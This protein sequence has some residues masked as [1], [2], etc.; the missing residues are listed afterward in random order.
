MTFTAYREHGANFTPAALIY[1]W[2]QANQLESWNTMDGIRVRAGGSV[3]KYQ[4]FAIA[5]DGI[6]DCITVYMEPAAA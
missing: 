2:A 6:R 4:Q 3:W 1:E 5:D